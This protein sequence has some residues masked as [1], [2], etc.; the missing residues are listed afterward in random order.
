MGILENS[1]HE[2]LKEKNKIIDSQQD[3]DVISAR[4]YVDSETASVRNDFNTLNTSLS[5]LIST[6]TNN[7]AINAQSATNNANDIITLRLDFEAE[8][9][10]INAR[11]TNEVSAITQNY[12]SIVNEVALI[13]QDF[14][15]EDILINSKIVQNKSA[16][17]TLDT[18][19]TQTIDTVRVDFEAEDILINTKIAQNSYDLLTG[20]SL[21]LDLM[22]NQTDVTSTTYTLGRVTSK[23]F[24]EISRN[25]T[26]IIYKADYAYDV[27]DLLATISYI[28]VTNGN[29]LVNTKTFTYDVNDKEDTVTWTIN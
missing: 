27:N 6:N 9:T 17:D 19:L 4:D 7:I 5:T 13:R 25:G 11:I 20:S 10:L 16:L 15:A 18:Q 2:V 26:S 29:I 3:L 28:D 22:L 14:E 1:L 12:T 23:S 8:D 24:A 21:R